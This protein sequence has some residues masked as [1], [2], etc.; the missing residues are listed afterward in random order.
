MVRKAVALANDMG[1]GDGRQRG[2]VHT[3][4][5]HSNPEMAEG[6]KDSI[7]ELKMLGGV[8]RLGKDAKCG[9]LIGAA[10]LLRY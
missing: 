9:S 6:A 5:K 3:D 4:E 2:H 8:L 7:N 1:G 10:A